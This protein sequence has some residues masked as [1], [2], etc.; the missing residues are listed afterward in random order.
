MSWTVNIIRRLLTWIHFARPN[1]IRESR[2]S[3]SFLALSIP[4]HQMLNDYCSLSR[5][6]YT[7]YFCYNILERACQVLYLYFHTSDIKIYS[8]QRKQRKKE[9]EPLSIKTRLFSPRVKQEEMKKRR[10]K[11][12]RNPLPCLLIQHECCMKLFD[13]TIYF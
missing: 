8:P 4:V 7:K 1:L 12:G 5:A 6:E 10:K 11:N 9:N 13:I 3:C 2:I